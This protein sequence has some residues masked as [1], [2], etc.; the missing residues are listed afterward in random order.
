MTLRMLEGFLASGPCAE[1]T[2]RQHRAGS[3]TQLSMGMAHL[4]SSINTNLHSSF[5]PRTRS[6]RRTRRHSQRH[7]HAQQAAADTIA[8]T[9]P[10]CSPCHSCCPCCCCCYNGSGKC[11]LQA[12]SHPC[13]VLRMGAITPAT[14]CRCHCKCQQQSPLHPARHLPPTICQRKPTRPL[15]PLPCVAPTISRAPSSPKHHNL[16]CDTPLPPTASHLSPSPI[17]A[18]P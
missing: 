8:I 13:L 6:L 18:G 2:V 12:C 1:S 4:P 3:W 9:K 17:A 10:P 16:K 5:S 11:D 15:R 14:M 7:Q